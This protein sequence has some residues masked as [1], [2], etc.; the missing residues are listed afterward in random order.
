M[1]NILVLLLCLVLGGCVSPATYKIEQI[2]LV[3]N[4]KGNV[5]LNKWNNPPNLSIGMTTEEVK[6]VIGEPSKIIGRGDR[7]IYVYYKEGFR[8]IGILMPLIPVGWECYELIFRQ[9]KLET[10][11]E[12]TSY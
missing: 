7:V 10:I 9:N 12:K 1:K 11:L 8:W 6:A 2:N 3:R 5:G 4:D